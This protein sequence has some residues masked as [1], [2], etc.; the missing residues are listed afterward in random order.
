MLNLKNIKAVI[1]D[2]EGTT[3]P[4]SFVIDT[5]FPYA[6]VRLAAYVTQH[7]QRDDI[8]NILDEVAQIAQCH[9][10]LSDCIKQLQLWSDEDIKITPLKTLQGLIWE[11]GFVDGSL[12]SPIYSD[13][14]PQLRDWHAQQ[15]QLGV[16]SSGSI[17]AQHLLFGHTCE[18][19]LRPYF[20]HFFDTTAGAKQAC[21][22]YQYIAKQCQLPSASM[23][24]ISDHSGEVTAALT[25]GW[26][27]VH[28]QR[29][30][31][32]QP[33]PLVAEQLHITAFNQLSLMA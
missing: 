21:T 8:K 27:A 29:P 19:D 33:A 24:F 32:K 20:S 26:Q 5:L 13:V 30:D 25:A 15:I 22:A 16:Y 2:I 18:G 12:R 28:I 3:T 14:L 1:V 23:L 11:A 17:A 9:L 31:C 7:A 4:I 10:S 6:R